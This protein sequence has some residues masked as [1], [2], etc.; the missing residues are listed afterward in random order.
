MRPPDTGP[1]HSATLPPARLA[2]LIAAPVLA[3]P[4]GVV[5]P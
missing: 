5:E 4:R 3:V 1:R 2:P